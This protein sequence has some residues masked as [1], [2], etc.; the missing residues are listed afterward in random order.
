MTFAVK[1]QASRRVFEYEVGAPGVARTPAVPAAIQE[2]EFRLEQ[3]EDV[4]IVV[5]D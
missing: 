3:F 2:S 1:I 4:A 5:H